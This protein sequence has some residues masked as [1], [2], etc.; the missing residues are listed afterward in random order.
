MCR[1]TPK[2]AADDY[3]K[4]LEVAIQT[5]YEKIPRT[6]VNI[7]PLFNV[8]GVYWMSLRTDYCTVVHDVL[9]IECPCAF[10]STDANRFV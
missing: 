6:L 10:D 9:P 2:E 1:P 3:E 5:I 8:S 4:A 7:I